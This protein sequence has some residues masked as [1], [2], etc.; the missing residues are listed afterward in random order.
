MPERLMASG[1]YLAAQGRPTTLDELR[2]Y[3]L[4]VWSPP[5]SLGLTLPLRSGGEW[6]V[7]PVLRSSDI[8]ML[9]ECAELGL[10]LVYGPAPL[11]PEGIAAGSDLV[12]VLDDLVGRERVLQLVIPETVSGIPRLRVAIDQLLALLRSAVA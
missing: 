1:A 6:P 2:R 10:G 9:R 11:L 7:A 8:H 3:P 4:L 12:P 5:D